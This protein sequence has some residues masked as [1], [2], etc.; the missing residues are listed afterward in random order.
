MNAER[1]TSESESSS[2]SSSS[3]SD[4]RSQSSPTVSSNSSRRS[5]PFG[6]KR[7]AA[8]SRFSL[9]TSS[10]DS[11][12]S[13]RWVGRRR[14][15]TACASN[16]GIVHS[17]GRTSATCFQSVSVWGLKRRK[18][19]CKK[20]KQE[21]SERNKPQNPPFRPVPIASSS[22]SRKWGAPASSSPFDRLDIRA[23]SAALRLGILRRL[24]TDRSLLGRL[25]FAIRSFVL[26]DERQRRS[27]HEFLLQTEK[28]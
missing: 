22:A 20:K 5:V 24:A 15:R 13:S 27:I 10:A 11:R 17:T 23:A 2:V 12:R 1:R 28:K 19:V 16:S 6:G 8:I 3:S 18:A 14:I 21:G 26:R 4:R 9:P 7:P 25:F